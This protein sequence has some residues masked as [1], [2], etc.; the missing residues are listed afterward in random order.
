MNRYKINDWIS[1]VLFLLSAVMI[2]IMI[3]MGEAMPSEEVLSESNGNPGEKIGAGIEIQIEDHARKYDVEIPKFVSK[4]PSQALDNLNNS[5]QPVID[6]YN[7]A[8]SDVWKWATVRTHRYATRDY[9]QAVV[10]CEVFPLLESN[11]DVST[12]VYDMNTDRAVTVDDALNIAGYTREQFE[13]LMQKLV[14]DSDG[15]DGNLVGGEV[16]GFYISEKYGVEFFVKLK[17]DNGSVV[18]NI[19]TTVIP[20]AHK[21]IVND[22]NEGLQIL[23]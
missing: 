16:R 21:C 19:V 9:L 23:T 17:F 5:M 22:S 8:K 6:A 11:Y 7:Y 2:I 14:A 3:H 10:E 4:E 1:A 13:Q 18:R 20:K 12:Y 15:A